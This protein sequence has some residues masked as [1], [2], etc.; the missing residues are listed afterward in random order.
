MTNRLRIDAVEN[1]MKEEITVSFSIHRSVGLRLSEG[2][3]SVGKE[4]KCYRVAGGSLSA[5]LSVRPN[6]NEQTDT[7]IL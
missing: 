3:T 2:G 7:R 5:C 6:S 4:F 1:S